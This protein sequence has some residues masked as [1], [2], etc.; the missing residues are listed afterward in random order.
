MDI[1]LNP[2]TYSIDAKDGIEDAQIHSSIPEEERQRLN[3]FLSTPKFIKCLTEI[4]TNLGQMKETP[5]HEKT[6]IL[7]H[8]LL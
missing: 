7:Q 8:E 6:R 2:F 5:K 1:I 3:S 4:S